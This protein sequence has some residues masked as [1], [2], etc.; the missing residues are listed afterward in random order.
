MKKL[1]LLLALMFSLGTMV[2]CG[3]KTTPETTTTEETTAEEVTLKGS[4]EGFGG[5]VEVEVVKSGDTITAVNVVNHSEST[6]DIAEVAEALETL[7]A[8]IVEANGTDGVEGVSGA[9]YTSNAI[10]DA[11]NAAE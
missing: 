4:A 2:A 1:A 9:T 11:V 3:D 6:D 10:I 5:P 7:P 8:A